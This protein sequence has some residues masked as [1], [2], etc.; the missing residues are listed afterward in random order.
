MI[1]LA[2]LAN[3]CSAGTEQ[4]GSEGSNLTIPPGGLTIMD[5]TIKWYTGTPWGGNDICD[6]Y[7]VPVPSSLTSLGWD[8][9]YGVEFEWADDP[10]GGGYAFACRNGSSLP[11]TLGLPNDPGPKGPRGPS[12][13]TEILYTSPWPLDDTN[14]PIS[15]FGQA[16][17][18]WTLVIDIWY[19]GGS[20]AGCHNCPG[21]H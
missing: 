9:T 14:Q 11:G 8:C 16:D 15:C 7:Y 2:L 17:S 20:P 18:G 13:G 21:I 3:G 4:T 19:P 10:V 5:P 6:D 1:G 12:P